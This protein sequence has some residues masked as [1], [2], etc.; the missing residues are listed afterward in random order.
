LLLVV[1]PIIHRYFPLFSSLHLSS[2]YIYILGFNRYILRSFPTNSTLLSIV[3]TYSTL[4]HFDIASRY[5]LFFFFLHC[6]LWFIHSYNSSID[7]LF[8][9]FYI[10]FC[11]S[12]NFLFIF[13]TDCTLLLIVLLIIH[14]Y[15]FFLLLTLLFVVYP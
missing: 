9:Y 14:S 13:L 8:L 4:I 2:F 15:F 3:L 5:F 7:T 11:G 1:F 6:C 12:P 10:I